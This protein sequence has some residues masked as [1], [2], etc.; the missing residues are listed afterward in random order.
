[1]VL[2]RMVVAVTTR[3]RLTVAFDSPHLRLAVSGNGP[4][5]GFRGKPSR[6]CLHG[7]AGNDSLALQ[8]GL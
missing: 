7:D 4:P 1:M 5:S 6:G 3:S 8:D 2:H